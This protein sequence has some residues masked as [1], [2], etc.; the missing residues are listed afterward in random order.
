MPKITPF[1]WFDNLADEAAAFYL[2]VFPKSRIIDVARCG[3]GGPRPA[4]SVMTVRFELDGNEFLALN[5]GPVHYGFDESISFVIDC[6]TE[7]GVD[8]YWNSLTEGGEDGLV[9]GRR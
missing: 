1:L 5:G 2:S 3:E 8:H 7:E 4:G 6:P 9:S